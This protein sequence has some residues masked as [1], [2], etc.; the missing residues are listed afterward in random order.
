[1][2]NGD[3]NPNRFQAQGDIVNLICGAKTQSKPENTVDVMTLARKNVRLLV[4]PTTNLGKILAFDKKTLEAIGKKLKEN[5]VDF[6]EED[7]GKQ[8]KLEAFLAVVKNNDNSHIVNV[9]VGPNA[10]DVV[11]RHFFGLFD[12]ALCQ[13]N[14]EL[15]KEG[16]EVVFI[17]VAVDRDED[18]I[19][20]LERGAM[21][22]KFLEGGLFSDIVYFMEFF[23]LEPANSDLLTVLLRGST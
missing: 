10:M 14:E 3:Y 17:Y 7:D 9:R 8:E 4:T 13:S 2:R 21:F 22:G 23:V 18:V 19:K 12:E 16:K 20:I 1:M 6:G 11:L 15:R 5:I